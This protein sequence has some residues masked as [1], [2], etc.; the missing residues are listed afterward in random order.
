MACTTGD[1]DNAGSSDN[2]DEATHQ[3][4]P[5]GDTQQTDNAE[6][7]D[8]ESGAVTGNRTIA[9]K[10]ATVT[11]EDISGPGVASRVEPYGDGAPIDFLDPSLELERI[12]REVPLAFALRKCEASG[13]QLFHEIQWRPPE[14]LELPVTVVLSA[15]PQNNFFFAGLQPLEVELD[16]PGLFR[17]ETD[18]A[19]FLGLDEGTNPTELAA[20]DL[21]QETLC[22]LTVYSELY[23]DDQT[24]PGLSYTRFEERPS[25]DAPADSAQALAV[26]DRP[27]S[28]LMLEYLLVLG[29]D[30]DVLPDR[31][32]L[33]ADA[34][35]GDFR[36]D[37]DGPCWEIKSDWKDPEV[38]LVQS[39]G[40]RPPQIFDGLREKVVEV[41][42]PAWS[43]VLSGESDEVDRFAA[44]M[45]PWTVHGVEM[46][47]PAGR[48]FD[49][50]ATAKARAE[51]LGGDH[52]GEL[53]WG[54]DGIIIIGADDV[55]K[56]RQLHV[57]AYRPDYF[58]TG[59]GGRPIQRG[60]CAATHQSSNEEAGFAIVVFNDPRIDR[61]EV[62]RPNGEWE[63]VDIVEMNGANVAMLDENL[64]QTTQVSPNAPEIRGY[65]SAG[66]ELDCV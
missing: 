8:E 20:D 4:G 51:E 58:S 60:V 52:I 21:D 10:G 64:I 33:A 15:A 29:A 17:I 14:G 48:D 57:E 25:V 32:W 3:T 23:I 27:V 12:E 36:I 19:E 38:S 53:P 37:R 6:Q 49:P 9:I 18:L 35:P 63:Q 1:D 30:T 24:E 31:W 62:Q 56:L 55:S 54:E 11:Y 42:D 65:D 39:R 26:S 44:M 5:T 16:R 45:S 41:T 13:T 28:E 59:G 46:L 22:G 7:V 2:R 47:G 50:V 66:N 40:C 43:V 61:V 34:V